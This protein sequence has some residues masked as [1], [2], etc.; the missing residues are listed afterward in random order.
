MGAGRGA[1]PPRTAYYYYVALAVI[2]VLLLLLLCY[3]LYFCVRR[4]KELSHAPLPEPVQ[5][6]RPPPPPPKSTSQ[7]YPVQPGVRES[8]TAMARLCQIP[9]SH[10]DTVFPSPRS[11]GRHSTVTL[12]PPRIISRPQSPAGKLVSSDVVPPTSAKVK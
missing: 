10:T 3:F 7:A 2:L 9:P 4:V 5:S 1:R 8:A 12:P 6:V 11:P